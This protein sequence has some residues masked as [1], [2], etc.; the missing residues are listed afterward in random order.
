MQGNEYN[1][2]S[3]CGYEAI[4]VSKMSVSV[5]GG[6]RGGGVGWGGTPI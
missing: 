1:K 2:T 6:E 5:R 3:P 4:T